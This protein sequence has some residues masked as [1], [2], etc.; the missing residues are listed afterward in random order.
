MPAKHFRETKDFVT[1]EILNGQNN[2]S[3]GKSE[4]LCCYE[5]KKNDGMVTKHFDLIAK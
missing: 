4:Y 2:D 3:G 1:I 5:V